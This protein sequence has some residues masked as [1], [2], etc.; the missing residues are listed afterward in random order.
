[1]PNNFF[2]SKLNTVLLL[3]LIVLLVIVIWMMN[4]NGTLFPS[5]LQKGQ[6][7]QIQFKL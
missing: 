7:N 1:M 5:Q 2:G 4:K 6:E 3:V